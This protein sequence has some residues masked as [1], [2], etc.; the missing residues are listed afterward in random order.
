MSKDL[1]FRSRSA[2]GSFLP[3]YCFPMGVMCSGALV[4]IHSVTF[5]AARRNFT[6]LIGQCFSNYFLAYHCHNTKHAH[7]PLAAAYTSIN[8]YFKDT[9]LLW[10]FAGLKSLACQPAKQQG[11]VNLKFRRCCFSNLTPLDGRRESVF[12]FAQWNTIFV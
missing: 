3:Q 11:C 1:D 2:F 10:C 6:V 9:S 5:M 4:L 8:A 7:A 12:I